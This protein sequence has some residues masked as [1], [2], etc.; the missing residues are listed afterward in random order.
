MNLDTEKIDAYAA[1]AKKRWG[2]TD[3]YRE[4]A[5]K[6][7][8]YTP[9]K[10]QILGQ[11]MMSIFAE[12]GA[13]M[14]KAPEDDAVQAQV[15]KLQDFITANYYTCTRPILSGLGQMY[16]A[17]GEMQDNIDAAGGKGTARFAAKAIEH[18][19]G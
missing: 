7:A 1:E 8:D 13:M 17:E 3:A 11:A 14:H 6:T 18:F 16:A 12:F 10:Q 15:R 19:C 2:D 5:G 9:E 4:C